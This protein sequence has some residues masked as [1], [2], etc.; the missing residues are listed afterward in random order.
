MNAYI[1][2]YKYLERDTPSR[3]GGTS[4]S[5]IPSS[6]SKE[7]PTSKHVKATE[8]RKPVTEYF[9]QMNYSCGKEKQVI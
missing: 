8:R 1:C 5:Q 7:G 9:L 4:S 2:F 3:G 6:R